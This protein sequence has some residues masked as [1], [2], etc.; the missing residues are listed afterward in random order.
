MKITLLTNMHVSLTS[1]S[2]FGLREVLSELGGTVASA[3]I[4]LQSLGV[5]GIIK[6]MIDISHIFKRK[7][8]NK[9]KKT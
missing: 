3:K 8:K 7:F 4:V 6:F 9:W 5:V 1:V 2:Y